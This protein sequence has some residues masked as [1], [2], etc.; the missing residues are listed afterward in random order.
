MLSW[1]KI[2]LKINSDIA[3]AIRV[4]DSEALK[5]IMVSDSQGKLIGTITD[6]D[7]RRALIKKYSM[8]T[9]IDKIMNNKPIACL[10]DTS[11]KD[12]LSIM[13]N[14]KILQIPII[15]NQSKIVGLETISNLISS[16]NK[17]SKVNID[18]PVLLMAGGFG[19]RLAPI[20][21]KIPKPMI[22]ITDKSILETTIE[23]LKKDGF[24]NFYISTHYKSEII[25][26]YFGNG[27]KWNINIKYINEKKPLGTAGCIGLLPKNIIKSILIINCDLV[28]KVNYNDIIKYH[29]KKKS[30]AT[31]CVRNYD[32]QLP[33]GVIETKNDVVKKITEKP[34]NKFFVNA[35]IYVLNPKLLKKIKKNI[36]IDMTTFLSALLDEKKK[37]NIYPIYEYWVDVGRIQNL[38]KVKNDIL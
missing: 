4:M 19:K 36:K 1:K 14:K 34:I 23:S 24:K 33:Y 37:I 5:L 7:I 28:T 26:K 18:N 2:I 21:D 8:N 3:N 29:N 17:V 11:K 38:N 10:K 30:L 15:D 32:F 27:K 13:K 6:G 25:R 20:T 9:K 12:I 22:K 16:K 31:I 35:G